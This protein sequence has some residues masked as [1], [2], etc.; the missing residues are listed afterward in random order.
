MHA[1]N[2]YTLVRRRDTKDFLSSLHFNNSTL[3]ARYVDCLKVA[4]DKQKLLKKSH[5]R[6]ILWWWSEKWAMM[7]RQIQSC[8]DRVD[9][10]M[11]LQVDALITILIAHSTH[12]SRQKS[13]GS[14]L[15]LKCATTCDRL[16]EALNS[17]FLPFQCFSVDNW[18]PSRYEASEALVLRVEEIFTIFPSFKFEN[19]GFKYF[20]S[21]KTFN[22]SLKV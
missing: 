18:T 12:H 20:K 19:L 3:I 14:S 22:P 7:I 13:I 1:I 10:I 16:Y 15:R 2:V 4:R 21:F 8:W 17:F 6:A 11:I 5:T 9:P